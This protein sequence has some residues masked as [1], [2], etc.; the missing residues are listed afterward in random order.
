M[1]NTKQYTP[2]INYIDWLRQIKSSCSDRIYSW[3]LF[4]N[5]QM[6]KLSATESLQS[7]YRIPLLKMIHQENMKHCKD[8]E[9]QE[10]TGQGKQ[11]TATLK[12]L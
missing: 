9:D 1:L 5:I 6:E 7:R 8:R 2:A 3:T 11:P 4:G 10:T 12:E